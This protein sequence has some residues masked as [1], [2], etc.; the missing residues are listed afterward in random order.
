M[1]KKI[2]KNEKKKLQMVVMLPGR[3]RILYR[4]VHFSWKNEEEK[5]TGAY[6]VR[7]NQ[8]Q[9]LQKKKKF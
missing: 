8:L 7:A 6:G 9:R 2:A 4:S 5:I 1:K 3:I